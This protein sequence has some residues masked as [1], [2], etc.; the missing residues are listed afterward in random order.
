MIFI[1]KDYCQNCSIPPIL[2]NNL[3][4]GGRLMDTQKFHERNPY[5]FV[6][7]LEISIIAV[8]FIVGGIALK[9]ELPEYYMYGSVLAILAI[10]TAIILLKLDWWRT[11]GFQR[12]SKKYM[13][14]LIIPVIPLIGN[15]FGRYNSI[16]FGFYIYYFLLS[17]LVGFAEEGIY[18][19]IILQVL[20]KRGVWKALVISSVLFSLS[21]I[22]NALA[23]WNLGHVL[24]QLTYSFALGFGWSAFALRTGTIWPLMIIH[25]LIDFFSFIKAENI[26]KSL[27]SSQPDLKAIIYSIGLSAI[28]I[29]YGIVVTKSMIKAR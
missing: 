29:I 18:R 5:L 16:Q 1:P 6:L 24:L 25:C 15:L 2:P 22:M 10:I 11:I 12:L 4:N 23:G 14:L 9:L 28:F 8:L 27:Q 17:V 19:G 3:T 13:L 20:L 26:F 7:I 21:H